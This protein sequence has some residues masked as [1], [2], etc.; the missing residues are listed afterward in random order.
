[1]RCHCVRTVISSCDARGQPQYTANC[2]TNSFICSIVRSPLAS[3]AYTCASI[4]AVDGRAD[5]HDAHDPPVTDA[6]TGTV[7]DAAEAGTRVRD[8][9]NGVSGAGGSVIITE[10]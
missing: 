9:S 3:A 2:S 6:Q 5:A 7:P 1:M 10:R 4:A 8:A